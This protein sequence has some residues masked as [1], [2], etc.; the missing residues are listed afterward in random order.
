[1][2][3]EEKLEWAVVTFLG[4]LIIYFGMK[5][6]S[7]LKKRMEDR[8]KQR[9]NAFSKQPLKQEQKLI[10]QYWLMSIPDALS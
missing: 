2:A 4:L 6:Y 5:C 1:L 8:Q 9:Q 10:F 3:N 7:I